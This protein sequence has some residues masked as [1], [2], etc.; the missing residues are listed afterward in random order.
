MGRNDRLIDAIRLF[1][2]RGEKKG[3]GPEAAPPLFPN[4]IL[5]TICSKFNI[6]AHTMEIPVD[7]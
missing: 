1:E 3:A 7:D 4:G 6:N 2:F 5:L